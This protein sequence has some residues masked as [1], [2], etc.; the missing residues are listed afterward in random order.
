VSSVFCIP[1]TH[2]P[3]HDKR[4]LDEIFKLIMKICPSHVV[5]L[6]DALDQ[7]VF[8]KYPRRLGITPHH[9]ILEGVQLMEDMWSEIRR[10]CP[11]SKF[12]QLMGNH[13][14]RISKRIVEKL[15]ELADFFS[16]KDFYKLKD[17]TVLESDR[18]YLEIDNVIYCHGWLSKS[19]DHARF[20]NKPTV[21][22]HRHRP[23]IEYDHSALWSMDCGHVADHTQMPL[24]Y[25]SSKMN[26]W[27]LACGLVED[28]KPRLFQL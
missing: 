28:R 22:G 4:A 7:Y 5:Q 16:H 1:D 11:G 18:D 8:S 25:T 6:G 10:L 13:D 23:C 26:K 20:F 3:Y 14:V 24:N 27:T 12:F 9:D 19:I 17:V 15:P 2:F 21:H